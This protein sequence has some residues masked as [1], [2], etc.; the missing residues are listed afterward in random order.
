MADEMPNAK[1][2]NSLLLDFLIGQEFPIS[3]RWKESRNAGKFVSLSPNTCP[4]TS[5]FLQVLCSCLSV[6]PACLNDVS[7]GLV[8]RVALCHFFH[9]F[10]YCFLF[11]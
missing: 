8:H 1:N 10:R 5:V 6:V 3:R 2:V 11:P 9:F 7:V 4:R